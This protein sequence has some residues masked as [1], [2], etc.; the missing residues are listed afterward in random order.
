MAGDGEH[1]FLAGGA[2]VR[3]EGL[4]VEYGVGDDADAEEGN[5]V[6]L[7][8]LCRRIG[9][10]FLTGGTIGVMEPEDAVDLFVPAVAAVDASFGDMTLGIGRLGGMGGCAG[11]CCSA[12]C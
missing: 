6:F 5:L 12:G 4:L 11:C 1:V 8:D 9:F 10:H 3:G 2:G 7:A